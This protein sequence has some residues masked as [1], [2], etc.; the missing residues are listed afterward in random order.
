MKKNN[1]VLNL[2]ADHRLFFW[3]DR[4]LSCLRNVGIGT[5][6]SNSQ[7]EVAGNVA[8]YD[9]YKIVSGNSTKKEVIRQ[10]KGK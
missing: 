5:L 8:A 2:C 7:L 9:F 6:Y 4:Y 1:P 3:S 10:L